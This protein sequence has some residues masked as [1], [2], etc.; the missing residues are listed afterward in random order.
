MKNLYYIGLKENKKY[1]I[2]EKTS[3]HTGN[4]TYGI[5]DEDGFDILDDDLVMYAKTTKE[6]INAFE[7]NPKFYKRIYEECDV[8]TYS[9]IGTLEE[10]NRFQ[11][12][13]EKLS[14]LNF[15]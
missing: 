15:N 14:I 1:F 7:N 6:V 10:L 12:D 11:S 5:R 3:P 9:H 13:D 8:N 4:I 2:V